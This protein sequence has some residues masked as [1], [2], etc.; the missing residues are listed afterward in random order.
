MGFICV[1]AQRVV[2]TILFA[3]VNLCGRGCLALL[4][5][6]DGVWRLTMSKKSD[7]RCTETFNLKAVF[8]PHD[9]DDEI[10]F[11]LSAVIRI[12]QSWQ[13]NVPFAC[14]TDRVVRMH[15]G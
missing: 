7:T 6:I 2:T 13:L 15:L 11:V 3:V 4:G 14:P 1:V 12:P 8:L 9:F 10:P 5:L